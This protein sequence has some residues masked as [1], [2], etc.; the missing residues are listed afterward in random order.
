[1]LV[2][3]PPPNGLQFFWGWHSVDELFLGTSPTCVCTSQGSQGRKGLVTWRAVGSAGTQAAL[4]HPQKCPRGRWWWVWAPPWRCLE[5]CLDILDKHRGEA[6]LATL[7]EGDPSC[8]APEHKCKILSIIRI[9]IQDKISMWIISG[10]EKKTPV[11]RLARLLYSASDLWQGL[12]SLDTIFLGKLTI[13]FCFYKLTSTCSG[14]NG[15]Q[16]VSLNPHAGQQHVSSRL[17]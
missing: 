2:P 14:E 5:E 7:F 16:F 8:V 13:I 12:G 11:A 4:Q 6:P 9:P 3:D 1:M 17:S 15:L 10:H